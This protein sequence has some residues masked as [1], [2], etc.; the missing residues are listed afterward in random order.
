MLEMPG[1][2]CRMESSDK[3]PVAERG[4]DGFAQQF[5][6][7]QY[8]KVENLPAQD[9]KN[10]ELKVHSDYRQ[11]I[12]EN[13]KSESARSVKNNSK[14]GHRFSMP[15]IAFRF[16]DSSLN[17]SQPPATTRRTRQLR[18][19]VQCRIFLS[20]QYEHVQ[21]PQKCRM[22]SRYLCSQ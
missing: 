10:L 12:D 20:R 4:L 1:P 19:S 3:W 16:C 8:F 14:P 17:F 6:W 15:K 11:K 7:A 21:S 13:P 2:T 9:L 22:L 5:N 18:S